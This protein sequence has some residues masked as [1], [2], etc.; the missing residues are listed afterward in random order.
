MMPSYYE[1]FDSLFCRG[2]HTIGPWVCTTP[3]VHW[4]TSGARLSRSTCPRISSVVR[5]QLSATGATWRDA[6][7]VEGFSPPFLLELYRNMA[8]T[9][10][11]DWEI[12]K[13]IRKGL[14]FGKHL[15]CTGN[16]ATSV[17]AAS[18]VRPSDWLTLA[19]RDLGAWVVRGVSL[20]TLLAQPCGRVGGLTR[21]WDGSLHMGSRL[22]GRSV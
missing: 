6:P 21:G 10:A 1:W 18:A 20:D 9:R 5:F 8:L 16:E 14:A 11:T 7:G 17:G 4:S 3:L 13:F 12:V 15:M 2:S 22:A 19:I